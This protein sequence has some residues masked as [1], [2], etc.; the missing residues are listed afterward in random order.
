[1]I[2]GRQGPPVISGL[3]LAQNCGGP[4]IFAGE[5]CAGS[6]PSSDEVIVSGRHT[7]IEDV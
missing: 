3:D 7:P 1:M 5:R 6:D 2:L 4:G